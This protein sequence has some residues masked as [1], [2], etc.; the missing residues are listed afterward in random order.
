MS[1]AND[2][3]TIYLHDKMNI[4]KK[5]Q[6]YALLSLA[7]LHFFFKTNKKYD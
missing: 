3:F 4:M 5:L 2:I 1:L 6:L 7:K